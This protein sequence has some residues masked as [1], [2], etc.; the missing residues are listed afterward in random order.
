MS[1]VGRYAPDGCTW[2]CMACGK[3]AKD[4]FGCDEGQY[5][6]GWDESCMLNA[7]L[8]NAAGEIVDSVEIF[9]RATSTSTAFIPGDGSR[10]MNEAGE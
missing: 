10:S 3:K 8:M 2:V 6:P 4:L 5:D 9:E 1:A 7:C